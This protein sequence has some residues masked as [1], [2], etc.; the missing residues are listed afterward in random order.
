VTQQNT[1]TDIL[2]NPWPVYPTLAVAGG[3]L[4]AGRPLAGEG[5][6][7]VRAWAER[8]IRA[9][10]EQERLDRLLN[11]LM[12]ALARAERQTRR[13]KQAATWQLLGGQHTP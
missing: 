6:A 13:K 8:L 1:R 3:L 4:A 9:L 5:S 11:E 12:A 2:I 10:T 7:I